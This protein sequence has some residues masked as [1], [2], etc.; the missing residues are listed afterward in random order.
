MNPTEG[1]AKG[2]GVHR[3]TLGFLLLLLA[4]L[5][6]GAP[7]AFGQGKSGPQET[8]AS[9]E[10]AAKALGAAFEK[11]DRKIAAG[12]LGDE[13]WA[14]VFSGDPVID[15]H[16]RAWF[17][18]LYREGHEVVAES[19]D[20]AVL[21]LGKDEVPYPVPIVRGKSR[22]RFDPSEGHED[23]LSRR[24]GKTELSALSV[25]VAYV[26]AQREYH[27][28]PRR[29]DG[30]R[31]YALQ[32]RSTPGRQDGLVWEGQAGEVAG[33]LAGLA[34]AAREE[35]R[36]KH[37]TQSNPPHGRSPWWDPASSL[38]PWSRSHPG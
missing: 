31:E 13:A 16:E 14:L 5:D 7:D 1:R 10:A 29:G 36:D 19:D 27:G 35:G 38:G 4:G 32:F 2:R 24:I 15:R 33:P 21:N 12:I 22:W 23:L 11:G 37:S 25:V 30:V 8:F 34:E 26:Q 9:P 28:Q 20:R 17:L 18:S 3:V 6:P